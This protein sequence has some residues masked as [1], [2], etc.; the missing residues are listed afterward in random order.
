MIARRKRW[1]GIAFL[2]ALLCGSAASGQGGLVYLAY[3]N[4][5]VTQLSSLD[6]GA[7][8]DIYAAGTVLVSPSQDFLAVSV[9]WDGTPNEQFGGGMV[10]TDVGLGTPKAYACLVQPNGT[11]VSAGYTTLRAK[12]VYQEDFAITRHNSDGTLD[13][14]FNPDK[15]T[16]GIKTVDFG[17]DEFAWDVLLQPDGKIIVIG[18][19]RM[20]LTST[21]SLITR[22]TWDGKIDSTYGVAGT[23][24]PS[25]A[26]ILLR[27]RKAVHYGDGILVGC[28]ARDAAGRW[29]FGLVRLGQNGSIDTSFGNG[30][31]LL[32][33]HPQAD[34][35]DFQDL[36]AD[37]YGR[38]VVVGSCSFWSQN[39]SD[40]AV[41]RFAPGGTPDISFGE[42]GYVKLTVGEH[43]YQAAEAVDMQLDG[44]ILVVGGVS[45]DAFFRTVLAR[46]NDD[47]TLDG[48]FGNGVGWIL[49]EQLRSANFYD[50]KA[51]VHAEEGWICAAG[52]ALF[53]D[54]SVREM[55]LLMRLLP[56][57]TFDPSFG[58]PSQ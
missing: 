50:V 1:F 17:A 2:L 34:Q 27:A 29:Q 46:W 49:P 25:F 11:L 44:K 4:A 41:V 33:G 47:G 23:V 43:R 53:P 48:T 39:C 54:N 10:M 32:W 55:G 3:P 8:G 6:L 30:G 28:E 58:G 14:T 35:T 51:L 56:D 13:R 16:F 18:D 52:R 5:S 9:H 20:D 21:T 40:L 26:G 57:G 37:Q 31:C 7:N 12:G 22:L 15:K 38:I 36:V 42:Q 45:G 19:Q 24:R